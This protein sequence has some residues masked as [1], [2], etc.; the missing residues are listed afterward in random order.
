M[1]A[2]ESSEIRPT[3][4][5]VQTVHLF[6]L[7]SSDCLYKHWGPLKSNV[8]LSRSECFVQRP[9]S[10]LLYVTGCW[11]GPRRIRR[12][13]CFWHWKDKELF[14]LN[15]TSFLLTCQPTLTKTAMKLINHFLI[16]PNPISPFFFFSLAWSRPWPVIRKLKIPLPLPIILS[17]I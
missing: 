5:W 10:C 12:R 16:V 17:I 14:C 9:V 1:I 8:S 6:L 4:G 2:S 7:L 11:P 3:S 15:G 13:H